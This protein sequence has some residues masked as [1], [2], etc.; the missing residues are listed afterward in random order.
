MWDFV[1]EL[2][3]IELATLSEMREIGA[4]RVCSA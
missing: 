4:R 1:F 2:A 3:A